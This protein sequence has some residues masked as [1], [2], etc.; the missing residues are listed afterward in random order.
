MV[1]IAA[2][3]QIALECRLGVH[4]IDA[5]LGPA[6]RRH[7]ESIAG[8][9]RF[10]AELA[11]QCSGGPGISVVLQQSMRRVEGSQALQAHEAV[12]QEGHGHCIGAWEGSVLMQRGV[13]GEGLEDF[14]RLPVEL[15]L[16]N[17]RYPPCRS[18]AWL[19]GG[20][21]GLRSRLRK[22]AGCI[23]RFDTLI[24]FAADYPADA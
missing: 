14:A 2:L 5:E 18:P 6:G 16:G 21:E 7:A 20:N 8:S 12:R 23:L 4:E 13:T 11:L 24:A 15:A 17:S 3:A 22:L 1:T 10:L 9:H 19:P